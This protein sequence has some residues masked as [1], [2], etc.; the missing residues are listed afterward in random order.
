ME[1]AASRHSGQ[2]IKSDSPVIASTCTA[3]GM[4]L[5][6]INTLSQLKLDILAGQN[7]LGG[8]RSGKYLSL[9]FH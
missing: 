3:C 1:R 6:A 8:R 9:S 5:T 7:G 2:R 4:Y